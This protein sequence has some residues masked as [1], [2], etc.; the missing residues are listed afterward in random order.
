MDGHG[1]CKVSFAV[2]EDQLPKAVKV[3]LLTEKTFRVVIY[4]DEKTKGDV[5]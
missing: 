4:L 5:I 1:G 3:S 2:P